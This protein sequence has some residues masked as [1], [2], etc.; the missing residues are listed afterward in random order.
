M[1][2]GTMVTPRVYQVTNTEGK[3]GPGAA[4]NLE[5]E[6]LQSSKRRAECNPGAVEAFQGF[7]SVLLVTGLSLCMYLYDLHSWR[8]S[9]ILGNGEARSS[10]LVNLEA[11]YPWYIVLRRFLRLE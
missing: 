11:E 9:S 5:V 2:F 6:R 8:P 1:G 4:Y 7:G 3:R 10:C